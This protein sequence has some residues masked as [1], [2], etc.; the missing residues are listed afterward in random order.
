MCDTTDL[1][2]F[3]THFNF[4]DFHRIH[5]TTLF[6]FCRWGPLS[7]TTNVNSQLCVFCI[8]LRMMDDIPNGGKVVWIQSQKLYEVCH[9]NQTFLLLLPAPGHPPKPWFAFSTPL[10]VL[11]LL[12]IQPYSSFSSH[13]VHLSQTVHGKFP[14]YRSICLPTL[15][16]FHIQCTYNPLLPCGWKPLS[17]LCWSR[18]FPTMSLSTTRGL[19]LDVEST[20]P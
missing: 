13:H 14:I 8:H 15:S 20:P 2:I 19:V 12:N 4:V 18:M 10:F 16:A 6:I 5:L 11:Q 3:D 7:L 9:E 1:M 17:F